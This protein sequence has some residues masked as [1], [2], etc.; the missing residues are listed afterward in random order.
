MEVSYL[1]YSNIICRIYCK[2]S[3]IY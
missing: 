3:S 1:A 2:W